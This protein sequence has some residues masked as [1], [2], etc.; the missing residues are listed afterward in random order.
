MSQL[1]HLFMIFYWATLSP[2]AAAKALP[3]KKVTTVTEEW[4]P[5]E[6]EVI[7]DVEAIES[8]EDPTPGSGAVEVSS[9]M[10][11]RAQV[12]V[13]EGSELVKVQK[14]EPQEPSQKPIIQVIYQVPPKEK[15]E[16]KPEPL[17]I[18][19]P[20]PTPMKKEKEKPVIKKTQ[21]GDVYNFYFRS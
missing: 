19:Q 18:A 6:G 2:E 17:P 21:D 9:E 3:I 20:E 10:F 14:I 11:D 1:F 4:T 16:P 5:V 15:P 13:P 8:V 12:A 7:E